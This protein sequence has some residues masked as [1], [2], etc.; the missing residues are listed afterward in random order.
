MEIE[1]IYT[2]GRLEF[3]QPVRLL[4]DTVKV[5]VVIPDHEVDHHGQSTAEQSEKAKARVPQ[6]VKD[7]SR[8]MRTRLDQIRNA[9]LPQDDELPELTEKQQERMEAFALREELKGARSAGY[10]SPAGCQ[11]RC[12]YMRPPR[13]V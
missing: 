6:E 2:K 10:G 5:R 3:L 4:T 12:G 1:A 8:K 13:R 9:P 11:H 7:A